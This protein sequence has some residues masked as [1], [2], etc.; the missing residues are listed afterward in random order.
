MTGIVLRD[1]LAPNLRVVFCG[2]A[3][4]TASAQRKLYY[5]GPGN[6][7]WSI[8]AAASLTPQRLSPEC[9]GELLKHGIGLTD[10]VKDQSGADRG[11]RFN[12]DAAT[13]LEA[14]I[15]EFHPTVLCFNGKRAA[16]EY[17][18]KPTVQY[19][20]HDTTIGNTIVFVAPSTSGA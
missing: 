7:F 2:T 8:L 17:L 5:A 20:R 19:G 16:M 14:K 4:G 18:R 3:L 10:I 12:T 6:R 1:L 15:R 13:A 9:Y 11:L